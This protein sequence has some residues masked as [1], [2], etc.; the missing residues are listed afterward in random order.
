MEN[1]S[2]IIILFFS[3]SIIYTIYDAISVNKKT[4]N[5]RINNKNFKKGNTKKKDVTSNSKVFKNKTQDKRKYNSIK[6]K[7]AKFKLK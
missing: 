3:L 1:L 5:E 4:K 2:K 7:N 6:K